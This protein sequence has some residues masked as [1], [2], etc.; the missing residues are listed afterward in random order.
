MVNTKTKHYLCLLICALLF[1]TAPVCFGESNGI[2]ID[3]GHS[4]KDHGA[5]SCDGIPEYQFND[6][7][8]YVVA[9]YLAEKQVPVTLTRYN[10]EELRL[11][12]RVGGSENSKL[13]LSLHHDS[14][15]P[16]FLYKKSP[17]GNCSERAKGFSIFVSSKNKHYEKSLQCAYILGTE[18]LKAGMTPSLHHAEHIDGENH[19]LLVSD[20][21]IYA[22]DGLYV[23]RNADA[24]AILLEAAVIVHPQ[25]NYTANSD[26][27]R[28]AVAEAVYQTLLKCKVVQ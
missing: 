12:K 9:S 11:T 22:F 25:D 27:F 5:L 1:L 21:G 28:Y 18:L 13:F 4:P 24:P 8:A 15:Q 16:R 3:P 14:V 17:S 2:I 6:A 26:V 10:Y 23:L 7:L 20:R 19:K